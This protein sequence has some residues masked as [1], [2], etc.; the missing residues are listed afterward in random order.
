MRLNQ[1]VGAVWLLGLS[2]CGGAAFATGDDAGSGGMTGSSGSTSGASTSGGPASGSAGSGSS[3]GSTS[4]SAFETITFEM[5]VAPGVEASYCYGDCLGDFVTIRGPNNEVLT[6]EQACLADCNVCQPMACPALCRAPSPLTTTPVTFK[7]NGTDWVNATCGANVSCEDSACAPAGHYVATL[8][9][10]VVQAE[11][12][13]ACIPSSQGAV[14]KD[15]DFD[16]PPPPSG[17]K[18]PSYNETIS[19]VIGEGDAGS[20]SGD[21]GKACMSTPDCPADMVCGFPESPACTLTGTCFPAPEVTCNA[22]S[23]GCACDGTD[24]NIACTGLPGG[25][26]TKPLRHAGVCADGG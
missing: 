13:P 20:G 3:G 25:Y 17:G 24:I 9:A 19:W 12:A 4:C 18:A 15:F 5:S 1:R 14:C 8:C 22:F 7:W 26:A 2:A 23:P 6:I 10:N 11:M 21:A 16:W